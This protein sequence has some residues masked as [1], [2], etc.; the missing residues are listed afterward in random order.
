MNCPCPSDGWEKPWTHWGLGTMTLCTLYSP[1]LCCA[2]WFV[3]CC[4]ELSGKF[5]LC[6]SCGN[7]LEGTENPQ[8]PLEVSP[9]FPIT[10]EC[11]RERVA[12]PLSSELPTLA[13]CESLPLLAVFTNEQCSQ[14]WAH[15]LA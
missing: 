11:R 5:F 2:L 12:A 14:D 6:F 1:R 9:P 15:T 3:L 10:L 13:L 4:L 7:G 8:I